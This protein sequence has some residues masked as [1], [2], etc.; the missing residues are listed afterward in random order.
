MDDKKPRNHRCEDFGTDAK[1]ALILAV[2]ERPVLWDLNDKRHFDSACS[3]EAWIS[4]GEQFNK[5]VHECRLAWKS[6]RDSYRYHQKRAAKKKKKG[7]DEIDWHLAPYLS[8]LRG[9]NSKKRSF[10]NA[11]L[12]KT[13]TNKDI[14]LNSSHRNTSTSSQYDIDDSQLDDNS[15]L[16]VDNE[17][18][19]DNE[20]D[21]DNE[22]NVGNELETD[23]ELDAD[24]HQESDN[25]M[26]MDADGSISCNGSAH[27]NV[28][29]RKSRKIAEP[30]KSHDVI[31]LLDNFLKKQSEILARP[32]PRPAPVSGAVQYWQ[33]IINEFEPA[34][35]RAAEKAVTKLLW[36]F[37]RAPARDTSKDEMRAGGTNEPEA[38]NNEV[39]LED[40]EV[41]T[42]SSEW[43]TGNTSSYCTPKP[44][45]SNLEE[46]TLSFRLQKEYFRNKNLRAQEKHDYELLREKAK[47]DQETEEGKLRIEIIKLD[48]LEKK[49]KL[50][51]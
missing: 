33:S 6:L 36:Q 9:T 27:S 46:D 44:R 34:R 15:Q 7:N 20:Q 17:L 1:I 26:G 45:K 30:I 28:K 4:I 43:T 14:R 32:A 22:Q 51:L 11:F 35:A 19:A 39:N 16:D 21:A 25:Q 2:Q 50:N 31:D 47:L 29:H 12:V 18:E 23:N 38:T 49:A 3:K 48:I 5:S 37:R 13:S 41:A 10:S 24:Y 42:L 40:E 8:F